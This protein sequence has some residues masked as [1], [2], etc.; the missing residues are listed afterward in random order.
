MSSGSLTFDRAADFYDATRGFP[1]QEIPHVAALIAKTGQF[2]PK[3]RVLEIGV[4][5]G[6]IAIPTAPYVGK[7]IGIDLSLP[8]MERLH[9]KQ[10]NEPIRL[11]QGDATQLPFATGSMEAVIAVHVFHLI[12]GWQSALDEVKRILRAGAPLLHGWG[13]SDAISRLI[14]E[15]QERTLPGAG[16]R[17]GIAAERRATFL[18]ELGWQRVGDIAVHHYIQHKT[19]QSEVDEVRRRSSSRTWAL[20][21]EQ[22]EVY[23]AA[24]Q[25]AVEEHFPN[26]LEPVEVRSSFHLGAYLPPAR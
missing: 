4:G 21:D 25:Q 1:Q 5:T 14:H 15:A 16:R 18:E 7:Y 24:A 19:P 17:P 12:P 23:V 10:T 9:T 2:T 3:S 22:L 6:R 13:G 8:M 11:I 20:T 26:P